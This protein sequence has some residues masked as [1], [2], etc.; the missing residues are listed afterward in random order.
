[1]FTAR[2]TN[3]IH[4]KG[5]QTHNLKHI[6]VDIP[7]HQLIVITGRSGS[8]KSSL[9]FDT[10]FA[11]GQRIYMESLNAYARQFLGKVGN[12]PVQSIQGLLPSIGMQQKTKNTNPRARVATSADLYAYLKLLYARIGKTYSPIT[13][14]Q[15]KK[16]TVDD[17]LKY[18]EK[19]PNES[20]VLIL[21]P[22][23][24]T[25]PEEWKNILTIE[26]GKGFT[27]MIQ[28][29]TVKLLEDAMQDAPPQLNDKLYLVIDRIVI[30]KENLSLRKRLAESVQTA[31]F[32][33]KGQCFIQT[34]G[35]KSPVLF[36]D[37][38]ELDGIVFEEP[39]LQL[40]NF[41]NSYGACQICR[42]WGQCVE[43]DPQKVIPYPTL[44]IVQGA[45]L[46]WE[47]MMMKE[48]KINFLDYA[49]QSKF[50]IYKP[51]KDL[52]EKQKKIIWEGDGKKVKGINDFFD[53]VETRLHKISYRILQARYRGFVTCS[54]CQGVGLRGDADYVKIEGKS[55]LDLMNMSV[56]ETLDFFKNLSL[57]AYQKQAGKILIENIRKKLQYLVKVGL[58]YLSLNRRT[59]TLSGGE[60]QRL[61]LAKSLGSP[62]VDVLYILDEPTIGLHPRDTDL[63]VEVLEDLQKLGNTVIVVEHEESLM[64]AAHHIID[65]GPGAGNYGGEIVFQGAWSDLLQADKSQT[66]AYLTGKTYIPIPAARKVA[67][68]TITLEGVGVHNLRDMTVSF[69]LEV[70]TVITGVSG[71]GKSSLIEKVL[72]PAMC[73][74]LG[75]A[76]PEKSYYTR[77][78]GHVDR[79][80]ALEYVGQT[81]LNKSSRSN[82]VTYLKAYDMIR[83][84]FS[85]TALS[86]AR[87]YTPQL[88]SFN[89]AGGRCETCMG[90]GEVKIEMQF[91]ADVHITCE[92][93]QGKRFKEAILAVKFQDK[94]IADVLA[95]TVDESILFFDDYAAITTKMKALKQ[96]GLGYLRLGQ[97][98]STFSGGEAQRV[99]LSSYLLKKHVTTPTL[100]IFD[101]PTTGLHFHDIAQLIKA[102]QALLAEGHTVIV[103]EH[104]TE[105]MKC[106]DW[107]IDLGPEAGSR[108]GTIVF[109]GIPEKLVK[110]KK[111][112]T[113]RYLNEKL[114]KDHKLSS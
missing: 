4:V 110:N 73:N 15:V 61:R 36:S 89:T 31:F 98:S 32:E 104:N 108:G 83:K 56:D 107:I 87:G 112:Q 12:P 70:L 90:D 114:I 49:K 103:I 54:K 85:E 35:E 62:L 17:V 82:V 81:P 63:L 69:P 50:P 11:R 26:I 3:Y 6:D 24:S 111:S 102:F 8:G 86:V 67:K 99:K 30:N 106:A 18:I 48:W 22:M 84:I 21:V 66:A 75:I 29:G 92:D 77:L 93:C 42:G 20:K 2:K 9:A 16:H 78:K 53:L 105:V 55:I 25:K 79:I 41:N 51:Y 14:M 101:E 52:S 59:K 95:M 13:G 109:E 60:Y 7:H 72:Y 40:F 97:S 28:N 44:S 1:M 96:V 100:F 76:N 47:G 65:I 37:I 10:I 39:T 46:P 27:R 19:L 34:M 91:M 94:N 38:F 68:Y 88:F 5:A 64:K 58:G 80:Q 74:Y 23:I 113:A 33:G 45:V 57:S 43:I 71:S